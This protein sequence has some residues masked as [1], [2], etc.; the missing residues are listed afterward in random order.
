M[1]G[2]GREAEGSEREAS[3][4]GRSREGPEGP[5][6]RQKALG[7]AAACCCYQF[8]SFVQLVFLALSLVS[9]ACYKP[10]SSFTPPSTSSL[11]F[12]STTR[13]FAVSFVV[14]HLLVSSRLV[15]VFFQACV[16]FSSHASTLFPRLKK[17]LLLLLLLLVRLPCPSALSAYFA[18]LLY[19]LLA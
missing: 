4:E 12:S 6:R 14:S 8:S 5:W 1:T 9:L 19:C 13:L 10:S 15:V 16:S 11:L 3:N 17:L 7:L 18:C 2:E